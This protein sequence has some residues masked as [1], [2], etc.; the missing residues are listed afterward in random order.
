[1]VLPDEHD[2]QQAVAARKAF[3]KCDQDGSGTISL[4]E[5]QG[6]ADYMG[7][8]IHPEELEEVHDMLDKDGSGALEIEEWVDFWVKRT[9]GNPSPEKQQ[10]VV[11][12]HA[13]AAADEN[14]SG[15]MDMDE[16]EA[17]CSDLGLA[18][19]GSELQ[20]A[21]AML[22]KDGNGQ[23]CCDEFV[24]W[25]VGRTAESRSGLA[26][27]LQKVAAAGRRLMHTDIHTAAWAGDLALVRQF[28]SAD[29]QMANAPDNTEYGSG[30][31]P[32]HYAAYQ[33]SAA[34]VTAGAKVNALT[35]EGCSALFFA[36]QQGRADVAAWLLS[37]G[38]DVTCCERGTGY[39]A[40]DIARLLVEFEPLADAR[41]QLP[42]RR[43]RLKVVE[44][45]GSDADNNAEAPV[46]DTIRTAV[47]ALQPDTAYALAVAAVNSMGEGAYSEFSEAVRTQL[48]GSSAK[49]TE[50]E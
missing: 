38:A 10:E 25:W 28:V 27:K 36:V 43:Y 32:L 40:L 33:A 20:E 48:A 29:A 41:D 2:E 31:R 22:D 1:M 47:Q 23:L 35:E 3:E 15:Y 30:M 5:L 12:R 49:A 34:L 4:D 17:L 26:Q 18:L 7:L 21:M 19:E 16:L 50:P 42:V 37:E 24:G 14:G 9:Q 11:A 6:L 39:T 44:V 8:P 13:F 46:T 45:G